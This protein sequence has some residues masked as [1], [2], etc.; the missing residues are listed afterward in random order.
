L[1][2]KFTDSVFC[3]LSL[4]KVDYTDA[5]TCKCAPERLVDQNQDH[6]FFV[7]DNACN[8]VR[9]ML[10]RWPELAKHFTGVVEGMHWS[11][12][13]S[14]SPFF[15]KRFIVS[16]TSINGA[17]AEQKNRII[18]YMKSSAAFMGQPRG[19]VF[20]RWDLPIAC[21]VRFAAAASSAFMHY[22]SHKMFGL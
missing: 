8:L 7:Y 2:D 19:L 3:Y 1:G 22:E 20:A 10:L 12:H 21:L 15:N 11:G 18:N 16:L 5:F 9:S 14:C 13:T 4:L 17:I 6:V